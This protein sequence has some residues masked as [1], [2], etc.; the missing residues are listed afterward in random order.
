MSRRIQR[1]L[2]VYTARYDPIEILVIVA[3]VLVIVAIAF[4]L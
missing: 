2:N 3:G 1:Q 4:S